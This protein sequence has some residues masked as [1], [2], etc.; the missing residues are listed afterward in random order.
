MQKNSLNPNKITIKELEIEDIP[1]I[2]DIEGKC[3]ETPWNMKHFS[4][5]IDAGYINSG[6][7]IESTLVGYMILSVI[8]EQAQILN[9]CIDPS[10]QKSGWGSY[11]MQKNIEILKEKSVLKVFLEVREG[12]HNARKFY[13]RFSFVNIGTRKKYYSKAIS[14]DKNDREDAVVVMRLL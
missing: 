7:F 8:F 1:A 13:K 12:N 2:L 11:L 4:D 5:C 3:Q 10:H 14:K 6:L 9:F